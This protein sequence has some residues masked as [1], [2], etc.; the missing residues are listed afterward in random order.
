MQPVTENLYYS[1]ERLTQVWPS[2]FPTIASAKPFARNPRKLANKVYGG[3]MGNTAP[4]DAGSIAAGACRRSPASR[5]MTNSALPKRRR[6]RPRWQ[7][8]SAFS[9]MA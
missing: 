4:D 1:A 8:P 9:L 7:P 5:T 6:R 2:R 3:R